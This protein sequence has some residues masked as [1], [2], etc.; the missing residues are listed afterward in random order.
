[1]TIFDQ[2]LQA[3]ELLGKSQESA[4]SPE[5][6]K[7]FLLT[8]DALWFVWSN[9]QAYELEAYRE[10]VQSHAPHWVIAAFDT[11]DEADAWLKTKSKPPDLALVLIA[12]EYHIVLSSRD[13][14]RCALV[15]DPNMEYHLEEL[16]KEGL[17]PAVVAF[18][19][20]EAANA[21]F[22][23]Q[24]DPPAQTVIQIGGELYLAAYYRNIQHRALFPFS[25]VERLQARRERRAREGRGE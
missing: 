9:G 21:W 12:D 25:L 22:D 18:D 15:P 4:Q 1:M 2:L 13:G 20:R 14:L 23:S 19:T 3:Q 11:H 16:T 7:L 5:E 17:P 10:D 24:T 8:I 6:K